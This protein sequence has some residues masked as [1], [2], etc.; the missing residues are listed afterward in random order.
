MCL[1][2]AHGAIRY[3][4]QD[5]GTAGSFCAEREVSTGSND[6]HCQQARYSAGNA[7][8]ARQVVGRHESASTVGKR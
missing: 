4:T 3:C 1:T 2:I 6:H 5:A 7:G 8:C